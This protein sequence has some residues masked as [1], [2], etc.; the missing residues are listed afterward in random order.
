MAVVSTF[1]QT[2]FANSHQEVLSTLANATDSVD[3]T[4]ID[5]PLF[6]HSFLGI[7][8]FDSGS[9]PILAG[10]ETG[11]FT[12]ELG[13][14][15]SLN[16]ESPTGSVQDAA[17]LTQIDFAGPIQRIKVTVSSALSAGVDSW[18]VCILSFPS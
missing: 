3:F 14:R 8:M 10:A 18:Q 16:L 1:T 7:L 11:Q 15:V 5:A 4:L 6:P 12:V 17:A 9:N 2:R 13:S